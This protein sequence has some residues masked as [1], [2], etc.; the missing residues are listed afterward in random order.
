MSLSSSLI[1]PSFLP[2]PFLTLS[3]SLSSAASLAQPIYTNVFKDY[4]NAFSRVK[5]NKL[6][7]PTA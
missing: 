3:P 5:R 1:I 6:R 7:K 2:N 4:A